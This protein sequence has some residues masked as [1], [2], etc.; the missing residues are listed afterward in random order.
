M[1]IMNPVLA[2]AL[3][4][5]GVPATT[6]WAASPSP[7]AYPEARVSDHVD[8]Y[9][10]TEVRDPYRWMEDVDSPEV[11]RWADAENALTNR[12][13]AEAPEREALKDRLLKL[14]DFERF[15]APE[16]H[17]NRLFYRH[18]SGLQNQA[19]LF[20]QEGLNGTPKMLLDP[21][22]LA[23][24]GTVALSGVSFTKDGRLMAYSTSE[25]G[26][27]WQTWKVREVATGKDLP[28]VVRWCKFGE[29]AWKE[30]GSGF[31]YSGFDAPVG[32]KAGSAE[33]HGEK[34]KEDLKGVTDAQ[35]IRFH[36]L[37]TPQTADAVAYERP[38]D[39]ELYLHAQVT[40][41]GRYLLL[42]AIKGHANELA[43]E[44]LAA[45][46]GAKP[47]VIAKGLD[48]EYT[49]AGSAGDT[50]WMLTTKD[51]P[52]GKVVDVDLRKPER[53]GWKLVIPETKDRVDQ[54]SIVHD[55]LVVTSLADAHTQVEM[56]SLDGKKKERLALPGIGTAVGFA[57]RRTDEDTFFQ[58]TNFTDPGSVYRL[59]LKS[60]ATTLFRQ[61]KLKF[62]PAQFETV[63]VF[64]PSKDGTRIPMTLS[65][66]KG[67]KRD[68]QNPTMLYGYG[69]FDISL[70]PAYSSGL[71]LWMEMGGIF[72]QANL[73]G[74]GEYG[75][76]WH[77]AGTKL[78]KQ[79]VF[80]DFIAA[81]EWLSAN[82]YTSPE[83]LAIRGGSNGGLLVGAAE[84]QRPEL[85]RAAVAQVGVMD[86]LRFDKFTVGFGWKSDYGSPS[87]NEAEFRAIYRY[88]PVHNVR[89]GV[90][91][92]PTLIT[93]A[94]HDDRVFPAHS[95][96][97]AAAMQ[98][99]AGRTPGSGPVLIRIE[100]RAGHGGGK[101]LS[102]Q[103][104]ETADMYAFLARE[105]RM[106]ISLPK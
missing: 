88:S 75:E 80:D 56:W 16:R 90:K 31:F 34:P 96:K 105:L 6:V 87:E 64:Y 24:D 50:L 68:G 74:G 73:R 85:F 2:A 27:D 76:T 86:M 21:N 60:G 59:D 25:A 1:R 13:L 39:K 42:Y 40:E 63:Q 104:E 97:F 48:A 98:A 26:S 66:R 106:P 83:R 8:T 32:G 37:G 45:G 52:N 43:V 44:D 3:L 54:V 53:L 14:N 81:A 19:V 55:T 79:N 72:A 10:G 51:A 65:Y 35:K 36:A 62:D 30:D 82:Q 11:K 29:A 20:W 41:D 95:F 22:T 7:I 92:P 33:A 77:Q 23:A 9:F 38:D 46:P 15:T 12:Y 58:F 47:V 94:D 99:E 93:T 57:G 71:M 4:S 49:A 17:G 70:T 102:K 5:S 67:L 28:D 100:S 101:P 103:V 78:H 84:L 91:Y 89:A 61:P 18:N 69:G